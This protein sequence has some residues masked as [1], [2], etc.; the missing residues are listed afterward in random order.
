MLIDE[1]TNQI[2]ISLERKIFKRMFDKFKNRTIIAVSH[3]LEN[4]DLFDKVIKINNRKIE[5]I[6]RNE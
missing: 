2:D 4:M 3:R 1:A 6:T 5:V